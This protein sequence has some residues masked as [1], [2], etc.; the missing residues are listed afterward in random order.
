[1]SEIKVVDTKSL[2][3]APYMDI[4]QTTVSKDGK[5]HVYTNV[6]MQDSV[7][8]LPVTK[9]REIYLVSQY[10]Y[11]LGRQMTEAV[12]G[13][14]DAKED[15]LVAAKRELKEETGLT[16]KQWTKLGEV[17][18]GASFIKCNYHFFLAQELEQ[19]EQHLDDFEEITI[20]KI[21]LTDAIGRMFS[22]ETNTSGTVIG[23]L[24]LD[25]MMRE[26]K[27]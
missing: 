24:L 12:A 5:E 8:V 21:K 13:M 19:N 17:E 27:L 11:L 22:P 7:F 9:A 26:G 25:K 2:Y 6:L 20:K 15:P 4:V 1:M 23:L 16:A 10:R 3:T 18:R 14:V